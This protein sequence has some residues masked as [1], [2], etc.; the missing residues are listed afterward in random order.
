MKISIALHLI[1]LVGW[2]GGLL[3]LTRVI[4]QAVKLGA[5]LKVLAPISKRIYYGWILPGF[6]LSL[7]T[8]LYQLIRGGAAFYMKQGWFHGKLTLVILLVIVTFMLMPVIK[9]LEAGRVPTSGKMM[10]LHGLTGLILILIVFETYQNL[11]I[12]LHQFD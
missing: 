12:F 7:I 5:N 9:G 8:G 1:A 2:V 10:T 6:A 11:L 3:I 4:Q